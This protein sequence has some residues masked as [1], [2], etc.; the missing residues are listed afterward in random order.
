V[1]L[2]G[3]DLSAETMTEK[4]TE[5]QIKSY[6]LGEL[7]ES[8]VEQLEE[9]LFADDEMFSEIQ[10]VEMSLVDGYVRNELPHDERERFETEYLVTPERRQK[11][12]QAKLFH[13]ELNALRPMPEISEERSD[14]LSQIFGTWRLPAMQYASAALVFL[15]AI[16]TGWLFYDN[17]KTRNELAMARTSLANSE[18]VLN[19][20]LAEKEAELNEKVAEQRGEGSESISALQTEIENLHRQLEDTKRKSANTSIAPS[21]TIATILLPLAR[22]GVS[23]ITTIT[24]TRETKVLNVKIPIAADEAN[25]FNVAVMHE[26]NL[27]LKAASI[28]AT[29]GSEGKILTVGLPSRQ[30]APG[31]YDVVLKSDNGTEKTRS[32]MVAVKQ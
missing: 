22:G 18:S 30:L 24:I 26:G 32:F 31:K 15:L 14:W 25:E 1:S 5:Q 8:E 2:K 17:W 27:V 20:S 3:G 4:T 10:A 19:Q 6:L 21:S 13:N 7:S 28:K 11:I 29:E 9:S 23:P 16:S 12:S